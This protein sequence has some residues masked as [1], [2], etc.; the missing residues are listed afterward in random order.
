MKLE[1]AVEEVKKLLVPVSIVH[2][3]HSFDSNVG[4][5]YAADKS[6]LKAAISQ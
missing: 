6:N 2:R 5:L 4:R 3:T 1:R